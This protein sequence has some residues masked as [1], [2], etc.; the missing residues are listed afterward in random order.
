MKT[1]PRALPPVWPKAMTSGHVAASG[2]ISAYRNAPAANGG[3]VVAARLV[4]DSA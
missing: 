4:R 2:S 3:D 1:H